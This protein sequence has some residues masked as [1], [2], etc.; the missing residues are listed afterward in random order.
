MTETPLLDVQDLKTYFF[1]RTGVVKAVDGV[2]FTLE[3]GE[4]LGIAGESGCG[5][6][7][8]ALSIM[9]LVPKPAGRTVGGKV[10]LEGEDLLTKSSQEMQAIR[11]REL[12]MILQDPMTSLNPLFTVGN[13]VFETLRQHSRGT[14]SGL[15]AR[16]L[17]LLQQVKIASPETRL[18]DYPHQMSGGMRQRVVG[19]IAMSGTP[20]VLIADEATTSLDA[21]I[22]YQYLQLLKEIQRETGLAIVFITHDFGIVAKMCDKVIVMYAGRVVESSNTR[23]LFNEPAHPY[24]EALMRSVPDV[25]EDVDFLYSIEGQ[26]PAL[27]QLPEGCSFAPRCPYVFD[28]CLKETP[29]PLYAGPNHLATCWRLA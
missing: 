22:Q 14:S 2:S 10:L 16:A 8:T 7:I 4:T 15:R 3:P 27:D 6:S 18:R 5:K 24:T 20:K 21:T 17:E 26:P 9:G 12:G 11:G 1:T 28:R 19:A 13:Q 25:D 29:V 23:D